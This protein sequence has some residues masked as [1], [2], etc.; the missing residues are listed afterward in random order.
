MLE[1]FV[2]FQNEHEDYILL[3]EEYSNTELFKEIILYLDKKYP[4][5][6][7]NK[8]VGFWSAEF[9]LS[10]INQNEYLEIEGNSNKEKL[11]DL[12]TDI[13]FNYNSFQSSYQIEIP[14]TITNEVEKIYEEELSI[15]EDNNS[16]SSEKY[17]T[18]YN[19][20]KKKF[21]ETFIK[22]VTYDFINPLL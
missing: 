12:H 22:E 14:Q 20:V 17:M 3:M 7:T 15:L 9:V 1:D 8:G 18:Y 10:I 13:E 6:K 19:T 5:W 21:E 2:D 11:K 16:V 4:E